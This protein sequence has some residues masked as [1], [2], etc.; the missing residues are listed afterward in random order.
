SAAGRGHGHSLSVGVGGRSCTAQRVP[1]LVGG[2]LAAGKRAGSTG[3]SPP[4]GGGRE[5]RGGGGARG[6]RSRSSAPLYTG[7]EAMGKCSGRRR[8]GLRATGRSRRL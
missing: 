8:R 7:S 6:E 2:R 4:V 3:S 1:R 5:Q